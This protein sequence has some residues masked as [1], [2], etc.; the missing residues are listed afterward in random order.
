M[1]GKVKTAGRTWCV[2]GVLVVA[3]LG[4]AVAS[5][6]DLTVAKHVDQFYAP[7][8]ALLTYEITVVH[9][10]NPA[11]DVG[12]FTDDFPDQ[13]AGCTWTCSTTGG[14]WCELASGSGNI[15]QLLSVP[16]GAAVSIA[17]T[18]TFIPSPGH[19]CAANVAVF[20][21]MDPD[22][23]TRGFATTCQAGVTVFFDDFESG[24]TSGWAPLITT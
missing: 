24:D 19:E 14:G 8:S 10:A 6:A 23:T 21:T 22:T 4:A 11:V 9:L 1:I 2:H 15:S 17:A 20:S 13:L 16:V 12:L 18:C 7:P 3:C 5:A